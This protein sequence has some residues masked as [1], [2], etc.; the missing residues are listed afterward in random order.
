[1]TTTSK[2]TGKTYDDT[3]VVFFYNAF[4]AKKYI[5]NGAELLDLLVTR[6]NPKMI[7]VFSKEDHKRL[8]GAWMRKEL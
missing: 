4:Q 5:E 3:S 2:I 7:F 8:R 6:E 1:M